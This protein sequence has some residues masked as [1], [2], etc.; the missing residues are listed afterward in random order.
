MA[1]SIEGLSTPSHVSRKRAGSCLPPRYV[2]ASANDAHAVPWVTCG[3]AV[4]TRRLRDAC[5]GSDSRWSRW[6]QLPH[7]TKRQVHSN[8]CRRNQA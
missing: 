1:P 6:Q 3:R 8:F 2:P 5:A 7:L 4:I